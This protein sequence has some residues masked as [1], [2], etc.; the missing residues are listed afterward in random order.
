MIRDAVDSRDIEEKVED[1][2]DIDSDTF[3]P[4]GKQLGYGCWGSVNVYNDSAGQRWAIKTFSPN[5]IAQEQMKERGWNKED[6]M[7]RES[8]PLDAAYYHVVP[9]IIERDKKGEMYIAMPVYEEGD[10]S[11]RINISLEDS[12]TITRD[13][14]KALSYIHN[15][16]EVGNFG[17]KKRKAH[18]DVKP[19]NILIKNKRAFLTDL[20]SSTCISIGG[21]GNKRGPHGDENYRAP[22]CFDKDAN[23]SIEADIWSLGSVLYE[24]IVG[25]GIYDDHNDS[26]K[27]DKHIAKKLRKNTPR[28]IRRFLRGCLATNK[29]KRFRTGTEALNELEK[30]IENLDNKKVIKNHIKKWT[31]PLGLPLV[32]VGLLGYSAATY[33]PQKLE[34]PQ[35]RI[36]GMLYS[37]ES[38][39]KDKIEFDV[40]NIKI[41]P[42]VRA[43]NMNAGG[44]NKN[45][46]LS[47]DNRVVAY[48]VKTHAQTAQEM[49]G[50]TK[51]CSDNQ[52][53][54]YAA[55][56]T[57]DERRPGRLGTPW[58]IWAK[59]IEVALTQSKTK[60]GRVDLEDVMAISRTGV[61]K[62]SEAKRISGSLDY[63]I[64]KKAQ[65]ISGDYII[66][67]KEQRFIDNWLSFYHKDLN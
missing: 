43:L 59:S 33:E 22:E 50:L 51:A 66:P 5:D 47:T 11:R 65:D 42:K 48:L 39:E 18:G 53:R 1:T 46:K 61:E 67:K 40:E 14:A 25:K 31:L 30:I 27:L 64:Y 41:L 54:K 8:V 20:G 34:M 26:T 52:F 60:N 24:M 15:Q 62:V 28:K 19:S 6:V 58:R 45:A 23:P 35:T 16:E 49:K 17:F 4:T 3:K 36:K 29:Y 38:S 44:L 32:L 12:L 55:Y 10:L 21:N 63:E 2:Y 7:R 56:T 57:P 37:T 9:R 13:I